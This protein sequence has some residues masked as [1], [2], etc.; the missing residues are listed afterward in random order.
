MAIQTATNPQTGETVALVKNQWVPVGQTATND[1]GQKAYLVN[2]QWLTDD[3]AAP[4]VKDAGFSLGDL[5]VSLGIG[6]TG[7][8]K[9][10]TDVA[11]AG[12]VVS[13]KLEGATESLQK[14]FTPERQAELQRQQARMKA[15]EESGSTL[16]EIK[17]GALNV[18]EAPLQSAAQA[19]GSFVPY[20]P[21]LFASPVAVALGLTGRSLSVITAVAQ[22]APAVI[23]TAQGAGA[24]KGSIYEGVLKAE[25]EAGVS[26]ELAK[27]KAIAAQDYFGKNF[28]QIALGSGLG[29]VAGTRGVEK[30]F[31]KAGR[32][33]VA[34]GVARRVGETVVKESLPEA[35]QGAQERV[36]QNI[37]LQREGRDVDTF[38]GAAGAATQEALTGALGAAPIAALSKPD[39]TISAKKEQD[40]FEQEKEEFRK[41]FGETKPVDF[42][43]PEEPK[44]FPGGYIATPRELS[45]QD[46]PE[47]YGIFPEGADKP[48]TTVQTQE[49]AQAK[50]Q[51]L[52][53]I[54]AEEQAR[55]VAE[56]D[57]ISKEILGEQRK[58]E[59]LEATGQTDTDQY[60]QGKAAL[61]QQEEEAAQKIKELNDQIVNYS[62][63]LTLAPVG[64]R[65]DV[66]SDYVVKRGDQEIGAFP[67]LQAAET[68]LR[69]IDPDTFKQADQQ[70]RVETDD[71]V[72]Q[73]KQTLTPMLE[74]FGLKDVGLNIVDRIENN[75]GGRYLDS[76]ID[77]SLTEDKPIETMRH[78]ALH[79]L[80][81]LQFFTPQQ[82]KAL[83]ERANKQW[84]KEY[85][86]DQIA[87][88]EVD[89][90]PVQMS[91][92]DAYKKLGYSQE[93]IVEEAIA[94][95]FGAYARGATPPPGMIAALFKKL[96]NFFTNFGQALR[97]AGFESADDVFQ[98]VERGELKSRKPKA[99]ST[100][101]LS[102]PV[103]RGEE[104]P[105][106]EGPP[107]EG[108]TEPT[109]LKP[110][111]DSIGRYFD[112]Q[113]IEQNGSKLDY[114]NKADF[115]RALKLANEEVAYQLKKEK[116]GLDWYE[117]DI[118]DAFKQTKKLI[119]EL[120][121]TDS[122]LLFSVMA[123]IMSPQTTAR[124]NWFI[125]AK[126][127]Q[128]YVDTGI[129]P[130]VNP[131]TGGLWQGG[132]T[133]VNK[134]TQLD[135]LN[136]MVNDMGQKKALEWL[137]TDHT[138]KEINS[139][140]S[141]YGNIKS[142]I[143]GKLT[144]VKPGLYAFGPKVGPFVSN[145]NGIPDVTVDKWMTRTF[146]RYFGTMVNADG[147][148]VDQPTEPQRRAIK[149]LINEVAKNAG[150]KPQQAQSL[151]WFYE[152]QLFTK[153]GV[154]SPSYGF[155]DGAKKFVDAGG[156]RGGKKG[157]SDAAE[158]DEGKLSLRKG[159]VAEVAPNP[160]H[161]SA[162]KWREMTPS[163][164]LNATKAVA[165]RVVSSVFSEL[166]LKGYNYEFST[167]T[168][169]GE[170]NPNIIVQAPDEATEQELDE[171]ARVLGYVL[172]Q[173]AMVAFDEDNKSSGDQ[174]GFVKVVIPDGMSP[175]DL[176][177][178][179]T[180]IAQSVP[181]ADGDTLRDGALLY[182]N[183]SA[184][185]DNVDTLTDKQ[186]HEAILDA[187]ESFPYEGK[188]RV[189]EP[190]TFHSAFIWPDT[191][192][193]YLKET[194]YGDSGKIQGE[195]GA[196]VRGQ[197]SS[198]LQTLSETA[199]SLRDRWID[200]RGAARLGGR[201]RGN[202]TDFGKPTAEYGKATRESVSAVGV[203]FSNQRR[204]TLIS[205]FYGTGLRGLE[206]ERLK[207][208][209]NSDIR[210]R[211]YFYVDNGKGVRPEAGVGG[212]PHVVRLNNL[213]D[214]SKDPLNIIKNSKGEN[215]A[216][217]ANQWERGIKKAG[218]DGY[219]VKDQAASQDYAVLIGKHSVDTGKFSLRTTS[220]PEFK[221]WFGSSKIVNAD[222]S[223]KVMYHGLAKDTTD[224]TRK[225]ERGAPIFLTDDAE[226]ADRFATDSYLQVADHPEKY[227]TKAQ[228]A[229]G[230]K[231]AISAIRKDYKKDTLGKEMIASIQDGSPT[232]EAR[233]Y[234]Q[235]EYVTMLPTGPHVMPLYVRAENPF[236]YENP[237]HIR[238]VLSGL[239]E[240]A[241]DPAD[242]RSG[243][244]ESIENADFQDAIKDAGFDSF[245][246][247]E[248]GRKNLAV[249][250]PN[251]VKSATGN[252]G[253]YSR[254]DN[255]VR[256]SLKNVA[257][258]SAEEA[259]KAVAK[260]S[261]PKT[262][263]FKQFIAGNQWV[264][265]DG[266]QKVFYHGTASEFFEF[267][268]AG[269]ASA[270]YLADT[271]E[272]AEAFGKIAEDRLREQVYRALTKD[273]KVDFF[274]GIVDAKVDGGSM[275]EREGADFMRQVKRKAPEFG[276]FGDL[277]RETRAALIDLSPTR[278][279]IMPLY[280][281]ADT[282][283]DF[284]NPDHVAQIAQAVR[285]PDAKLSEEF[286]QEAREM[287]APTEYPE[288][289]YRGLPGLLKQGY[290]SIIEQEP[291]QTAIRKLGFDGYV[292]RRNRT[293][294]VVY[295][296][297]S[298]EQVK[299]A[300]GNLGEFSR[301]SKNIKYSLK[302]TG[303]HSG[304]LGY[305]TDTVLGQMDGR[306]T[307]HFGTG[308]YFV[309]NPDK[310]R[311]RFDTRA[312]RPIAQADLSQFNL[313][314]P[315][316]DLWAKRLHDGLKTVNRMVTKEYED[317]D[318]LEGDLQ[319]AA[320][321]IEGAL[322][323]NQSNAEIRKAI[324][325][326]VKSAK[327]E[328]TDDVMHSKTYI[329]SASTRAMK[330]LGFDGID[331]RH[332]P[333][334]DN[335]EYGTVVYRESLADNPTA[336]YSLPAI[337]Q[338]VQD[339]MGET[340][341][342]AQR[343]T[344]I[345]NIVEAIT[346]TSAADFRAKYLNR[347]NQM[348]I[349]DKKL[350]EKMGGAALLADQSAE[351]A[352]LMSDLGAGI[353][354]SAMGFED[355]NGGIPVLR[356]GI[357]TI[358]KSVKGLI[359]SLA[360]LAQQ[361][362]PAVYQRYQY[363]AMVKRGQRLNKNG[364]LTG[365]DTADVAFAKILE[366]KHPEFVS[367]QKD[368][369]AF[370][371]GL[372]QYMVDTGVLSKERGQMYTKYAD[373]IPFYRQMDGGETLGP[374]LFQ[375]LSGV[376]PPKKLK[377]AI[378]EEAPLADFLETM[379]RNTQSSIQAGIKNYAAQRAINVASQVKAP[380]MGA[381]RLNFKSDAPD[382]INVLEKGNIV[383]YRTADHLL[384]NAMMSLNQSEIPF[385][386]LLSA[387]ADL[388]RS[389]VTKEPGFMMANILRDSLSAWVTSGVKMTPIAGTVINFGKGL[390]RKS[391]GFE[392]MLDAGIIGGYEFSDNVERS[393]FKLEDDLSR[394]AGKKDPIAYRP[395]TSVWDALEKG[396]TASDAAT[397]AIIYERV[398]KETGNEAEALYRSLEVMNFHRK[399]SSPLI[400][401]LTAAVPFFNARL[402]GLDLF[403]RAS[404]GNMN[405]KDAAA[406]QR[407]FFMRGM[408]MMALSAF[409]WM[410]VSDDEEY[411]KQEQETKDN[412]WIIP[413]VGA[414]IPIPF[415][416]GVLFKVIPERIMAYV[417]GNDTGED[418]QKSMIR[419]AVNT[420]AFN[421][422]PQ[423]IKPV[424]E[425]YVDFNMF[426]LRP[427]LG[428]G[429]KDI[430]PEYQVSPSTSK[431]AIGLAQSLGLS[432]IKVDHILKG[433]T[434]TIGMYAIDTIDA[435]L[436]QFGDSPKPSKRFE[437][438]PVIK[439]F[440]ADPEA[441]G[442][443]TQFYE[444]KDA[445]D[446]TVR[447]MNLLEKT[448]Q[449]EEYIEYVL[450]NQGP[451]ALK[452]DINNTEKKMTELR[453]MKIA[454]RS[455]TM[456]GDEKRDAL[457]AIGKMENALT[458]NIQEMKKA[459]ASLR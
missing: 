146:N 214:T 43:E 199:I 96:K 251:Q 78:E 6:A 304:D 211:V 352:A 297:Y 216:E 34:P 322:S 55:L 29:Y 69:E 212:T 240:D 301:E 371:N 129:I 354:A 71:R 183:F 419:S 410:M 72:T 36:A 381:E 231:R 448:G 415:E 378:A 282:P 399:G 435:V 397:R 418:L 185:N 100:E 283:F 320:N 451:L 289:W 383:S 250:E 40:K 164:R 436:D 414:K 400:R 391:P 57:K 246:V 223:P 332:I 341:T 79:A 198:R 132:T 184:Y 53:E 227:L 102:L 126:G 172:D 2:N 393:G 389:L 13:S 103:M 267:T 32:D 384:V 271:P 325:T 89:G 353:A 343:K 5:G 317:R 163:E 280:A 446:T 107:K 74:R 70:A 402:Q 48:L 379:V 104:V 134:K 144:D 128:H 33:T 310:F 344:V 272:E 394:K 362:D 338:V 238:K 38:K 179:R 73:L 204:A 83:E 234:L 232:A 64:S 225:T 152:Q 98:R 115:D 330:N 334:F 44:E 123:G 109:K 309:S 329:D 248:H 228:L 261:V 328:L 95:A 311:N 67:T 288:H 4:P 281:R 279:A 162:E 159:V 305:G 166:G 445:V 236:D 190:E 247:K 307:G 347:Y 56:S 340:T 125:A 213:Y 374:N 47:S 209:E 176:N 197:G 76:L 302:N 396:T 177:E 112:D 294:P 217:R 196:D 148:I 265:E 137:F 49:E 206:G 1:K 263:E 54:R 182:G 291:V 411:K 169:E 259:K 189:S 153:I 382:V 124:D 157:V 39:T 316:A 459:I 62:A 65:T 432:P 120:G 235:K 75:A 108:K 303:F 350:A 37:A 437:Q 299:S 77:I 192:N 326:A 254:T 136:N 423:T 444:L 331:V 80:K 35:A 269:K 395:F 276:S 349:Y 52:S 149:A 458:S 117:E 270:I 186:Y 170:V 106:F 361:G 168:Y 150:I 158:A 425:A 318:T 321:L 105:K 457:L 119:P 81:D 41:A 429:M 417:F 226:F 66:Q 202:A 290:S 94:D 154:N 323:L 287:G 416:V 260:T 8:T 258:P 180:H 278:S 210:S 200:A 327:K 253:Q 59:V 386:G 404:T 433:Y 409:Y 284:R 208:R 300:T 422:I 408:T 171:L 264:D 359:A 277:E 181:Q 3:M 133:A 221:Q 333:E 424:L 313:A 367:V 88:I 377:G 375:S 174:A 82:Y 244:W 449:T 230:E 442:N 130:G 97:G 431:V 187:I 233:E 252:T 412:N 42:K 205:D 19:I 447:T 84:I 99:P 426:T 178:L 145:L 430:E 370:N 135:F 141:K 312:N 142:G 398:L 275:T 355:R 428:Q 173:K 364:T 249:Y 268:P 7:S 296:V 421:P 401:I 242:I 110:N 23:G 193:D 121:K 11:G 337:P 348:S 61:L 127:F 407:Q 456:G 356:N 369:V 46:V 239:T 440:I 111:V 138:V 453:E 255:D 438:L 342:R 413:S 20:L 101:K 358:D 241:Y 385:I 237:N 390:A 116:S 319:K 17:A 165:N 92:L 26:P 293:S 93:A 188:I 339:R 262:D 218:F 143:D 60:V 87:E 243:S 292:S 439:R 160:D 357:T 336:K 324:L 365:I 24:V 113:V 12:N 441:R 86:Q 295:A 9:A 194:R 315:L 195:A 51:T 222:G 372:V 274:Q 388:L 452:D 403:Y 31:T 308:V 201:E 30:L 122:R 443:V 131:E 273:E 406:I 167:G 63:P 387:P 114:T 91:R 215:S 16:Q 151:L 450:K 455:S 139:F 15:A 373:Y 298:P 161:I 85:L 155:S 392:A 207:E 21:A 118:K 405:N 257:F 28:D 380:G 351:S 245:Y 285:R 314:K 27:Q 454:V 18:A 346:P 147:K 306:G 363:W 45:R 25:T 335:T 286:K 220:S 22:K 427:I 376:K 50:L 219:L 156:G 368:L 434:G 175:S 191:R 90:K 10:L 68:K 58:L 229:E 224:F 256:Y 360:P 266:N 140:R 366:Q 345:Q 14:S 203:H 420:F